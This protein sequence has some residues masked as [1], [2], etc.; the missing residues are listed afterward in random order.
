MTKLSSVTLHPKPSDTYMGL[1]LNYLYRFSSLK[2]GIVWNGKTTWLNF[3]KFTEGWIVGHVLKL[4]ANILLGNYLS[5][6][7]FK[8][9]IILVLPTGTNIFLVLPTH[10]EVNV[11]NHYHVIWNTKQSSNAQYILKIFLLSITRLMNSSIPQ[12]Y[13]ML[14]RI[15]RN[16]GIMYI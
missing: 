3:F 7:L 8:T 13:G 11:H 12:I 5:Y 10:R 2:I 1:Y 15:I 6:N 9:N 4:C 16:Q 14:N